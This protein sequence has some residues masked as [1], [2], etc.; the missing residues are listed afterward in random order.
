MKWKDQELG[1]PSWEPQE[2]FADLDIINKYLKEK[3]KNQKQVVQSQTSSL[4]PTPSKIKEDKKKNIAQGQQKT[5]HKSVKKRGRPRKINLLTVLSAVL[6][7]CVV[8]VLAGVKGSFHF[9]AV[10][11]RIGKSSPVVDMYQSCLKWTNTGIATNRIEGLDLSKQILVLAKAPYKV[12]GLGFEC[13]KKAIKIKTYMNIIRGRSIDMEEVTY[14]K[15]NKDECEYMQRTKKCEA[16]TMT[17]NDGRCEYDGKP[18]PQYHYL[19]TFEQIG[20]SCV[21][22]RKH[23]MA[24]DD[25]EELFSVGCKASDLQCELTNSIIVWSKDI[26]RNCP[27]DFVTKVSNITSVTKD[28]L[29]HA[30]NKWAFQLLK[31]EIVCSSEFTKGIKVMKTTEGLLL[32]TDQRAARLKKIDLNLAGIHELMLSEEDGLKVAEISDYR[33][34][35][36]RLCEQNMRFLRLLAQHDDTFATIQANNVSTVVYVKNG[37][38]ILPKCANVNEIELV[39]INGECY[40]NLPIRYTLNN[41]KGKGFLTQSGVI[42]IDSIKIPCTSIVR[43]IPVPN[44]ESIIGFNDKEAWI[45]TITNRIKIEE[46]NDEGPKY[47]FPHYQEIVDELDIF[48]A[49]HWQETVREKKENVDKHWN[50]QSA[51]ITFTSIN[52]IDWI[53][54]KLVWSHALLICITIISLVIITT[55]VIFKICQRRRKKEKRRR[56]IREEL[57][58]LPTIE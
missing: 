50:I 29:F 39:G 57:R 8:P 20:V 9:C 35:R 4:E 15:V 19:S 26:I 31:E 47:N 17:C 21:V 42:R 27:L 7:F 28:V 22:E 53:K 30:E 6:L 16:N 58:R 10:V 54:S 36:Q 52:I 25:Q 56:I 14:L 13:Q 46:L 37:N 51:K 45:E 1:A 18:T 40:Q 41:K 38:I 48:Q 43:Y 11:N 33:Q 44:S 5:T 23:I 32:T 24:K 55:I 3:Q 2:N 49:I 12:N 34:L